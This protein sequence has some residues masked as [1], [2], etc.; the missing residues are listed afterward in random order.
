M[1]QMVDMNYRN[2]LIKEISVLS[3]AV[4]DLNLFLDTHPHDMEAR[5]YFAEYN[6]ALI[7]KEKEFA[8]RYNPLMQ[9]Y[10]DGNKDW[11]WNTAPLPWEGGCR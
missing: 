8:M 5:A 11:C 7:Q 1:E 9:T 10:C 6:K 2:K 3:F 4:Y